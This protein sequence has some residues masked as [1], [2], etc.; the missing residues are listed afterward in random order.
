[1]SD[2]ITVKDYSDYE[3]NSNGDIRN[4]K[5]GNNLLG[6]L[7]KRGYIVVSLSKDGKKKNF[8]KHRLI[9]LHFIGC[10]KYSID[11]IDGQKDN[12]DIDNLRWSTIQENASNLPKKLNSSSKYIGVSFVK[13][14]LK[15]ESSIKINGKSIH[16]STSETEIEA[17]EKRKAYILLNDLKFYRY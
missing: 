4:L 16:F 8:Y 1:M 17:H 10:E 7:T 14:T 3:I 11:H 9:G 5:T 15:W 12:N 2:Y 6:C 13:K